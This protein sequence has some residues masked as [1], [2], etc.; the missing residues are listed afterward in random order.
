MCLGVPGKVLDTWCEHDLLMG[1]VDFG[2]LRQTV[3]LEPTPHV[4][5]GQYVIVHVGVSLQVIDAEEAE[6]VFAT[7]REMGALA[8]RPPS[9]RP[10]AG[11]GADLA[12]PEAD[13]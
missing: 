7:L 1:T 10:E 4:Q 11:A 2:G 8:E 3:C 12:S 9:D 13:R 5:R 6:R